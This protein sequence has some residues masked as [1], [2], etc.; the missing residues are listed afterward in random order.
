M[1]TPGHVK[2]EDWGLVLL[3]GTFFLSPAICKQSNQISQFLTLGP[4]MY[5]SNF[6]SDGRFSF[7]ASGAL[8]FETV[9]FVDPSKFLSAF[10]TF[11]EERHANIQQL[12]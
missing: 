2:P 12:P 9:S 7:G 10:L 11:A 5:F 3:N 6:K 1:L 8:A 4:Y